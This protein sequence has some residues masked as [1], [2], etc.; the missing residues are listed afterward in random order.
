MEGFI[1]STAMIFFYRKFTGDDKWC[2]NEK[3]NI[4]VMTHLCTYFKRKRMQYAGTNFEA[5]GKQIEFK[6]F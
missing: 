5:I 2:F 6:I 1:W 4:S 3:K